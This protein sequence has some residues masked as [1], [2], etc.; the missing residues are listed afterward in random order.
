MFRELVQH[1]PIGIIIVG[2]IEVLEALFGY[3]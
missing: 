1:A 3:V 2:L